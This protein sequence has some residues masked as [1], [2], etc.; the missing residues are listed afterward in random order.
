MYAYFTHEKEIFYEKCLYTCL[1]LN[2]ITDNARGPLHDNFFF[3]S[4]HKKKISS[5]NAILLCLPF[6]LPDYLWH[7]KLKKIIL[8]RPTVKK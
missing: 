8:F 1:P 5:E 6:F 7:T 4:F 2:G 3:V